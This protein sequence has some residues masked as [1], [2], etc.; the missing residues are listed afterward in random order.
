MADFKRHP[1]TSRPAGILPNVWRARVGA[2]AATSMWARRVAKHGKEELRRQANEYWKVMPKAVKEKKAKG[3]T[4]RWAERDEK[5]R[6]K[7]RAYQA[8][9][10]KRRAAT[11]GKEELR[12]QARESWKVMPKE[13][14]EKKAAYQAARLAAR[15]EKA[16]DKERLRR[17]ASRAKMKQEK[18]S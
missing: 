3:Q 11:L 10:R 8:A 4:V 18:S 6:A 13:F 1:C 16:K 5:A 7:T 12:R 15:D 2:K 17:R 9:W 14:K